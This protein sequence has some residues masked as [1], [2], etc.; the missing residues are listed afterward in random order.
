MLSITRIMYIDITIATRENILFPRN[1]KNLH[2]DS[3]R[4]HSSLAPLHFP[5]TEFF[6]C[7]LGWWYDWTL[8]DPASG[9]IRLPWPKRDPLGQ[10]AAAYTTTKQTNK[11]FCD[12][13]TEGVSEVV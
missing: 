9:G 8:S 4:Q 13:I 1:V 11:H 3:G 6:V 5:V 12:R 7:F 2:R 10:C